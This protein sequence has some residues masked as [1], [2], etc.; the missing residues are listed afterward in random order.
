MRG[1]GVI[2]MNR[3]GLGKGGEVYMGGGIIMNRVGLVKVLFKHKA[4]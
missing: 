2:I 3:V 4:M 1:W